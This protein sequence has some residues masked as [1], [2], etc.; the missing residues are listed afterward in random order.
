METARA[1]VAELVEAGVDFLKIYEMVS[2]EVFEALVAEAEA[3]GLPMDGHVPLSLRARDVGPRVQSLEHLR[4]IEMDCVADAGARLTERRER[5][6]N[7]DGAPGSTLRS[8][9]H[10][11]QRLS[12]VAAYDETEC[13]AVIAAMSGTIQVPTLRLNSLSLRPPSSGK[14]GV[15]CSICF[16]RRSPNSGVRREPRVAELVLAWT[17]HSP[18]GACS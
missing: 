9:L 3:H 8:S 5:L 15:P 12:A 11:L 18:R 10:S 16:R 4:N 7:P 13:D 17:R 6:S 2:P 1:N 14:I